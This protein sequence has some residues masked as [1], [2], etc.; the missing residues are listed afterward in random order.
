MK[1]FI[2]H[3]PDEIAE[4]VK[5]LIHDNGGK[6]QAADAGDGSDDGSPDHKG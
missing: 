1:K 3:I 5:K 4:A 6:V 2:C